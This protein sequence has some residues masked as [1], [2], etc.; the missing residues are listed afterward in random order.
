MTI[1]TMLHEDILAISCEVGVV[2]LYK[3]E[4]IN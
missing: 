4:N 3:R 2:L 1:E